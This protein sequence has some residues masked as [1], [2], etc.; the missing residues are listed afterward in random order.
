MVKTLDALPEDPGLL[1]STHR[2]L[3]VPLGEWVAQTYMKSKHPYTYN[4]TLC[5]LTTFRCSQEKEKT[6]TKRNKQKQ[7][8]HVIKH[9]STQPCKWQ[10]GQK[11]NPRLYVH[12]D[13]Q[14]STCWAKLKT[15][16]WFHRK[17][18]LLLLQRNSDITN[19]IQESFTRSFV[20]L[21][22]V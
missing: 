22:K 11:E 17:L 12:C 8:Q 5:L 3:H 16:I 21:P 1:P 4:K 14:K 2:A 13:W 10:R 9:N 18:G 19:Q 7:Y 6:K 15:Y 20:I